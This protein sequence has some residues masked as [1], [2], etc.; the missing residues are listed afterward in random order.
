MDFFQLIFLINHFSIFLK[1]NSFII[2]KSLQTQFDVE[3]ELHPLLQLVD[4]LSQNY[5]S[6]LY[7]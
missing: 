6:S 3:L 7:I 5:N 4:D 1:L 2:S